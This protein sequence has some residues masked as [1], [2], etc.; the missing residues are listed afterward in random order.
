MTLNQSVPF[1]QGLFSPSFSIN[2]HLP[3]NAFYSSSTREISTQTTNEDG[4]KSLALVMTQLEQLVVIN[5]VVPQEV[6]R[7][8]VALFIAALSGGVGIPLLIS[9]VTIF[10][11]RS[12]KEVEKEPVD[13]A[14]RFGTA[15][16]LDSGEVRK[17]RFEFLL[18]SVGV[19][20]SSTL[21][22]STIASSASLILL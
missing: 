19:R 9:S 5:Y 14:E 12:R 20:E 21:V 15:L 18:N 8:E 1:R 2:L 10:A 22:V 13:E 6:N 11:F 16:Y 7:Y 4:S 3:A 17:R